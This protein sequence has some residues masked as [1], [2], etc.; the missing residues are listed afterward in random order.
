MFHIVK[1]DICDMPIE[2]HSGV[3]Y[4]G[5]KH[6]SIFIV[7]V[8]KYE[9]LSCTRGCFGD[10]YLISSYYIILRCISEITQNRTETEPVLN[11]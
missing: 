9:P 4:F 7:V 3:M 2:I 1:V 6:E 11:E 10:A 5:M 8:D